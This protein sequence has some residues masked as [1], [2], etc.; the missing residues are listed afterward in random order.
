MN[1]RLIL[2]LI[3][4]LCSITVVV[5]DVINIRDNPNSVS[6]SGSSTGPTTHPPIPD[7]I[8]YT[9]P[10]NSILEFTGTHTFAEIA[11][12][13]DVPAETI[14]NQMTQ[15]L[16]EGFQ[17]EITV[18]TPVPCS[19][20]FCSSYSG[21]DLT[22]A[23]NVHEYS[24]FIQSAEYDSEEQKIISK[25]HEFA[26]LFN[27]Y[28]CQDRTEFINPYN[29]RCLNYNGGDGDCIPNGADNLGIST[30]RNTASSLNKICQLAG[31]ER[32]TSFTT[33][34]HSSGGF[35]GTGLGASRKTFYYY[36]G[37][38]Q[39][40]RDRRENYLKKDTTSLGCTTTCFDHLQAAKFR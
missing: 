32:Y 25:R 26:G 12:R 17:S 29:Y 15:D 33:D 1:Q 27:V 21:G 14:F 6:G 37:T 31:F 34:R 3:L 10:E 35:L 30:D 23:I 13:F 18:D 16:P 24:C 5:S 8:E 7:E 38:W 36:S 2:F 20:N 9:D 22:P 28:P 4:T 11:Q 39:S 19:V 40:F